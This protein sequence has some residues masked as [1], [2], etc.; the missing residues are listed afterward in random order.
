V[1]A[2]P[3]TL[4]AGPFLGQLKAPEISGGLASAAA[5]LP[6]GTVMLEQVYRA[7]RAGRIVKVFDRVMRVEGRRYPAIR[8]VQEVGTDPATGQ[9][10]VL[11]TTE[12]VADQILVNLAPG[13]TLD[14]VA[15]AAGVPLTLRRVVPGTGTAVAAFDVASP[16]DVDAVRSA[17][18]LQ[19]RLVNYAEPDHIVRANAIPNDPKYTDGSLWGMNNTGQS[20]GTADADVDAPE[21]W[22][23]RTSA[24][25]TLAHGRS[26][27]NTSIDGPNEL[28]IAVVDTGVRYTHEDIA[29]NMWKNPGESGGGK[30]INGM[31]DDGNGVIDDVHGVNAVA[32]TGDP[33]DDHFHGTHCAGTIAG[34][35]H[36]GKGVTG[37]AWTAKIAACKFLASDGSG[38][39]SDASEALWYAWEQAG[40]DVI[41]C[42]WGGGSEST[43]VTNQ[44]RAAGKNGA[45]VVV[46]AGNDNTD[47]EESGTYPAA[48]QADNIV[49]VAATTRTDARSGFSNYNYGWCNVGAPGSDI[50]SLGTKND[51][52]YS[53]LSGTSMATP[54]TAGI[55]GLLRAQ[56][57]GETY[58]QI[59]NRLYRGVDAIPAL[60]LKV[61][62][63]GRV[64]LQ[65]SLTTTSSSPFND[66]FSAASMMPGSAPHSL[67]TANFAATA[68]VGEPAHGVVAANKTVWYQWTAPATATYIVSTKGSAYNTFAAGSRETPD[69]YGT[70]TLDT[71]LGVYTGSAVLEDDRIV[72][73][74]FDDEHPD[75]ESIRTMTSGGI[76]G[77]SSDP[78]AIGFEGHRILIEDLVAAIRDKR[79]PMIPGTEAKNAVRLILAAYES[80]RTR[81]P[82]A[83]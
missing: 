24:L 62:T 75:D 64:N 18:A 37:V 31:D 61:Q 67:R 21:G 10:A 72:R 43:E 82:V 35:G 40:A 48:S 46:A 55:L 65:K 36:N 6:S 63:G 69:T 33:M 7:E 5:S 2:L 16:A 17:V 79:P 51:S 42:S 19:K 44:I 15:Q 11:K 30:E 20:S 57:P 59:L 81:Q 12:M 4:P 13:V 58:G 50:T 1:P 78:R 83:P 47:L 41:S 68:E 45:V 76:V 53:V 70:A 22:D 80:G 34:V 28:V 27:P 39:N 29:A 25:A 23:T 71:T 77:G 32:G 14:E 60:N 49:T 52:D 73:W 56:Y 38:A 8:V 54:L 3:A 66:S 74:Q 9:S 26:G